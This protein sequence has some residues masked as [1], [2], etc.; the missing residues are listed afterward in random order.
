MINSEFDG[1]LKKNTICKFVTGITIKDK[2]NGLEAEVVFLRPKKK[3]MLKGLFKS[4]KKPAPKDINKL[5][6]V[7]KHNG[8]VVSKGR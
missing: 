5:E 1:A 4:K 7:I 6:I 2:K 8:K 3:G